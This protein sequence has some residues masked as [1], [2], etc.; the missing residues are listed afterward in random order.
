MIK[1]TFAD[2][3]LLIL[4]LSMLAI[5][6]PL[7]W[8]GAT[9]GRYASLYVSGEKRYTLDLTKEKILEIEGERGVSKLEI[10][11]GK[12][13]FIESPCS[14]HFCIRSGWLKP[15]IGVIACLPNGISLH[16]SHHNKTYD[17][18]NF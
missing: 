7:S 2:K 3:V 18:I 16:L 12:V 6:Y 14:T 4:S 11:E 9:D 1:L 13:R 10:A 5:V 8:S 17:A 15:I